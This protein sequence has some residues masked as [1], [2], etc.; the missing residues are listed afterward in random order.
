MTALAGM[1]EMVKLLAEYG[2]TSHQDF[3]QKTKLNMLWNY[4]HK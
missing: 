4:W 1:L 3:Y 2:K